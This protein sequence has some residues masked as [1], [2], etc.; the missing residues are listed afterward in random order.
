MGADFRDTGQA[1]FRYLAAGVVTCGTCPYPKGDWLRR[2][3]KLESL[4][5]A[6]LDKPT[7]APPKGLEREF[8]TYGQSFLVLALHQTM[9]RGNPTDS[10]RAAGRVALVTRAANGKLG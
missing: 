3:R 4:S 1:R 6:D 9:H 2:D 7:K 10:R 8:A 5:E